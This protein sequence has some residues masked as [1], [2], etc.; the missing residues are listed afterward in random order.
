MRSLPWKSAGLLLVTLIFLLACGEAPAPDAPADTPAERSAAAAAPDA[1]ADTSSGS[2]MRRTAPDFER[3]TL[4]G[5]TMRRSD[6]E[7]RV[8][9][10]NFWATWCAPCRIE[11]PRLMT[12]AEAYDAADVLVVGVSIDEEGRAVVARYAEALGIPYPLIVDPDHTM[13]EAYGGHYA[14]PTT[15]IIAPDGTLRQRFMRVVAHDELVAAIE[16]L[17]HGGS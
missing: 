4:A 15:F 17:L 6:W 5:D 3:T 9:V 8:V 10:L 2:R 11:I 7:G 16:P 13:A 14:V 12:L 1:A